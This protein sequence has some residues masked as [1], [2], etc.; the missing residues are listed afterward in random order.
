[1]V[2]RKDLVDVSDSNYRERQGEFMQCQECGHEFGGTQGDYFNVR[3][4]CIFRCSECMSVNIALVRAT[5]VITII[6]Q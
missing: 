5:R 1:M 3:M 4:D 2:K 6:K